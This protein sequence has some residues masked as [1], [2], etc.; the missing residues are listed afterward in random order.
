MELLD[1]TSKS[2]YLDEIERIYMDSFPEIERMNFEDVAN[3]KSPNSEL[4]GAFNEDKL[5]GFTYVSVASEYAYIIYLAIDKNERNKNLGSQVL[6]K[7]DDLFKDKTKV[8]CVE[9]PESA[10]DIPTRRINFYKRNGFTLADFEFEYLGQYYYS[11]Y[12]GAF[13][14][15][16]FVDFLLTCFPGCKDFKEIRDYNMEFG[17]V[18]KNNIEKAI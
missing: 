4:L 6:E 14:K 17:L 16:K 15:Q 18:N 10:D 3:R 11:M 9:K 12:N 8:L 2:E 1:I 7:I 5:I 13:D